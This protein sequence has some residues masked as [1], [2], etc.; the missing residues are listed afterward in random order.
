MLHGHSL[1]GGRRQVPL[2]DA[3]IRQVIYAFAALDSTV[4]VRY[5]SGVRTAFRESIDENGSVFGEIVFGSD[6]YPGGSVVDPNSG[7]S[8]R[9]AAA[10]ELTH[11][12]RWLDKTQL[13]APSLEH[14]D[15]ALTSL[16]AINR[17]ERYLN[18]IDV[19]LLAA[20]A[21]QRIRLHVTNLIATTP[22]P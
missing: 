22:P 16:E 3:D 10:H 7:L 19:R 4:N 6:I 14:L 13:D 5:E 20:D 18:S 12:Y 21:I 15:E 11:Y 8:L 2:T 17:Y 1:L 9:A